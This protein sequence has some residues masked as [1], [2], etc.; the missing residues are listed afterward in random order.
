M[1]WYGWS[2][3]WYWRQRKIAP[4]LVSDGA[5]QSDQDSHATT[6]TQEAQSGMNWGPVGL[7]NDPG[8]A[9]ASS[10]RYFCR[11]FASA[12]LLPLGPHLLS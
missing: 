9:H 7:G 5:I 1:R 6:L 8:A 2:D 10:E 4:F 11:C 3:T 12:R